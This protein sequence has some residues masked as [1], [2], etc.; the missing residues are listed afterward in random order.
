[1]AYKGK[2]IKITVDFSYGNL[3]SKKG[4][5]WSTPGTEWK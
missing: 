5:E 4:K 1:M 2:T 3:K